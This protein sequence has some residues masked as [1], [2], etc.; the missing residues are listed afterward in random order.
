MDPKISDETSSKLNLCYEAAL[1]LHELSSNAAIAQELKD[2]KLLHRAHTALIDIWKEAQEGPI[3]DLSMEWSMGCQHVDS[4]I[5]LI[6]KLAQQLDDG[7]TDFQELKTS[8][9]TKHLFISIKIIIISIHNLQTKYQN[10]NYNFDQSVIK[11]S[12]VRLKAILCLLQVTN[13]L[14]NAKPQVAPH[15]SSPSTNEGSE[16]V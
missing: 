6:A 3:E 1:K 15:S 2:S 10:V 16:E 13:E 12:F 14:L 4:S 7:K 9:N 5:K 11:Q 8:T